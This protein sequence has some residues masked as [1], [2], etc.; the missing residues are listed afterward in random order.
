MSQDPTSGEIAI[1]AEKHSD[2]RITSGKIE[3]KNVWTTASDLAVKSRGYV[4]VRATVP[5][6]VGLSSRPETACIS[7]EW[8]KPGWS[9]AGNLAAW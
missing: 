4:E 2:G 9:L 8:G 5:A 7:G 1:K 3:T 6:K